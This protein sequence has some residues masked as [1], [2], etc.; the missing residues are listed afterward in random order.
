[1]TARAR[2]VLGIGVNT[3]G[4]ARSLVC[5]ALLALNLRNLV[6]VRILFDIGMA[7]VAFKAAVNTPAE[8]LAING[9]AVSVRVAHARIA[10][11]CKT[12]RLR[13]EL[14]WAAQHKRHKRNH[15]KTLSEELVPHGGFR[16]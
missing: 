15:R 14:D 5:M 3:I 8:H 13:P 9:N 10:M 11:A 6:R 2:M 4:Q 12:L 1:M 16:E 7:V